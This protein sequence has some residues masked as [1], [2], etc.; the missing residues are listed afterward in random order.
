MAGPLGR[1]AQGA[2]CGLGRVERALQHAPERAAG[3]RADRGG[4]RDL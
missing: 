3:P 2:F 1:R 4:E